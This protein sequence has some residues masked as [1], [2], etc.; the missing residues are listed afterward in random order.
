MTP[1]VKDRVI[2][3]VRAEYLTES[4]WLRR[5][6]LRELRAAASTD[7]AWHHG[8]VLATDG[9]GLCS[10]RRAPGPSLHVRLRPE[11]R[12]LL[13]ER[14]AARGMASATYLAV[15]VRSHLHSLAPLPKDEL[16]ALKRAVSELGAVG[17]NLNQ[18][19]RAANESAR[20]AG[21]G[22]D[23]FRATLRI[24]EGLRDHIKSLIK[25]NAAS[26]MSGHAESAD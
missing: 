7:G 5:L 20:V 17:R 26:W 6:V 14:A 1:E 25:A 23:E 21:I 12:L 19:A 4:I 13:H 9:R 15:L 3:V 8:D 16:V 18:I 22:H 24:C 10:D 11:D 2:G